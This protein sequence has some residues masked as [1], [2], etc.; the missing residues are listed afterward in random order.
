VSDALIVWGGWD[1]HHPSEFA[2]RCAAMLREAGLS[3]EVSDSLDALLG[4][5]DRRLVVPIWTMGTIPPEPL[6]AL[7]DAV[8]GGVGLAGFHG[9]MGDAFRDA[10]DF[11]FAVGGQ[12]VAHPDDIKDYDVAIADHEHEITRGLGDF[13]MRSE[14]YYMHVDP[15]NHVLATTEFQA[16]S[17]PWVSGVV[18]PVAWTRRYGEGRVFYSSLGH[19]PGDLEVPE[20]AEL[21][22]RGMLWA[23]AR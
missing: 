3:V 11:Q 13:S 14:Q 6:A 18:M 4:A 2:D 23:A 12:F 8:R 5:R 21:L 1:G 15:S 16:E 20:A 10:T 9:G 7:L 22:R 19:Q 17:A